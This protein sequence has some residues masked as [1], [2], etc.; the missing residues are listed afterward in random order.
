MRADLQKT[1][2]DHTGGFLSHFAIVDI[3]DFDGSLKSTI[4]LP[5]IALTQNPLYLSLI[6]KQLSEFYQCITHIK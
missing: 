4:R 6:Q 2:E 5:I 1:R 3:T